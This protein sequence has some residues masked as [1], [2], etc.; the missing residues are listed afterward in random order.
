MTE[1]KDSIWEQNEEGSWNLFFNIDMDNSLSSS[2]QQH[3]QQQQK[4]L[5]SLKS[6]KNNFLQQ[7]TL[8]LGTLVMSPEGI[9]RLIR[10]D[11]LQNLGYIKP[12]Q[13][14]QQ[15]KEQSKESIIEKKYPLT[16][17]HSTFNCFINFLSSKSGQEEEIRL[18]VKSTGKVEDIL[19]QLEQ[20]KKINTSEGTYSLFTKGMKLK[21]DY[22]FE[23]LDIK[24]NC[25]IL[26]TQENNIK[27]VVSRFKTINQYWYTYVTD[28][29]TF[30]VSQ[31]IRLVGM[32]LFGSHEGKSL[33]SI[34]KILDGPSMDSSVIYEENYEVP[35][36]TSKSTAVLPVY[37]SKPVNLNAGQSYSVCLI[38]KT[39][40]NSYYGQQGKI[41]VEGEK[42]VVFS[43]KR[44]QGRSGGSSPENGNFP[45]FYYY[46]H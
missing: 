25:K 18:K 32:G 33:T 37:F 15:T 46:T 23:Q 10:I 22:S 21:N 19:N 38:T 39:N 27:Y 16:E 42:G 36:A 44:I 4:D 1:V 11:Q 17:L 45:E 31:K 43:F 20:I 35:P 8:V 6:K 29:I 14:S 26:L 2:S 9:V 28:G 40:S 41:E 13:Q 5:E 24:N 7:D 3:H 34:L 30:S 12:K